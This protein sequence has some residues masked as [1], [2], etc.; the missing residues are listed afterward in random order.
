LR[1][2]WQS[3]QQR[4]KRSNKVLHTIKKDAGTLRGQQ[5]YSAAAAL[6]HRFIKPSLPPLVS[7]FQWP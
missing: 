5:I 7:F 3:Q 6:T 1:D 4:N 2:G